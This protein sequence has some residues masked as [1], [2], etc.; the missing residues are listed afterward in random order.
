M[1][2]YQ[3]SLTG[4]IARL[5]KVIREE[6]NR[7]L[8]DGQP[9]GEVLPWLNALP[10]VQKI[11]RAQFAGVPIN[12][13]NLSNWRAHG[14]KRWLEK[15]ET[16]ANLNQLSED[17]SEISGAAHGRLARGAAAIAAAQILDFLKSIPRNKRSGK[18]ALKAVSAI[19][20]L[21]R[22]DQNQ[23][24]LKLERRKV[25]QRDAEIL[26]MRDKH[27]RDI[28]AVAL[29]VVHDDRVRLIE[30]ANVSYAEK[31]ELVGRHLFGDL[32]QPRLLSPPPGAKPSL[33]AAKPAG[34]EGSSSQPK[35]I[36]MP[37]PTGEGANS[38]PR[39]G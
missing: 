14:Y 22:A 34:E 19:T 38:K 1:K 23:A 31:I 4:K 25:R 13:N 12:D 2:K 32:W 37:K 8:E 30:A 35:I 17:A 9:S 20:G 36:P 7:R 26:L 16:I 11:L 3:H 21:L 18:D 24:R 33:A 27:H 39:Q 15:Q 29:R 5:P 28:S 6:L 10:C